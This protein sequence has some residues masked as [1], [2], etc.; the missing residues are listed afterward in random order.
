MR[1]ERIVKSA[2]A[3]C[4]ILLITG[5]LAAWN[6]PAKGYEPSIYA[7]TPSIF[8]VA[9]IFSLICGIGIIVQQICAGEHEN[10]NLW[11]IGLVL[12][13]VSYTALLSI[14]IIRDYALWS[15]GD[16][17]THLGII[18][19][20]ISSGHTAEGNFY[21]ISHIYAAQISQLLNM[22][23]VVLYRLIPLFFALLY[24][25]N[26][27]LLA[28]AILPSKG[29]TILA[30][31][32]SIIPLHGWYLNFTPNHLSNLALPLAF[33]I[34]IESF[35][36]GTVQWKILFTIMVFLFPMFHTVPGFALLLVLLTIRLPSKIL[37]T[38][39]R[40]P[41]IA[42][43]SPFR[44][45]VTTSFLL[46]VWNI[47]WLSS[48]YIWDSA[49]RNIYVLISERGPVYLDI[50]IE[51]ILFAE[52]YG[53]S[54]ATQFLKEYGG[55]AVLIL[56]AIIAFPTLWKRMST[57]INIRKLF[58]L[59]APLTTFALAIILLYFLNLGFG[60]LR[61]LIYVVMIC[62]IFSGF[63]LYE[64]LERAQFWYKSNN[65]HRL[66]P[67]LVVA[68]LTILFA[69]GALKL[70]PSRYILEPNWQITRSEIAGMDWFL[71]NKDSDISISSNSIPP[72]R[73]ADFLLTPEERKEHKYMP[74]QIGQES[75]VP[76]HFGY[77]THFALGELYDTDTYLILNAKDRLIYKEV[78]PEI[79]YLRYS[80]SD[81]DKLGQDPTVDHIYS[82][83]GFDAYYIHAYAFPPNRH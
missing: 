77:D 2:A 49:I 51:R 42:K 26:M 21:P 72:G 8:W 11:V 61:L 28:K 44:S 75:R 18:Q 41:S 34:L 6:S 65:T 39:S 48:F 13:L 7:A 46:L 37:N 20:V 59:Y 22:N 67:L 63:V 24:V 12:I 52:R 17:L 10:N 15:T 3:T 56:L 31:I 64:I 5:V 53:Y 29:A 68:T 33:F 62:T 74:L 73:F 43:G 76:F 35:T 19:N 70:Y 4:F 1:N 57:E 14:W 32:V 54:A 66:A 27:Y 16:P 40:H 47:T 30:T 83:G 45:T 69:A 23:P 25:A 78:F 82:N 79:E 80:S 50:L 36:T 38:L 9:L 58:S 60:P 55:T 71:H 81:F